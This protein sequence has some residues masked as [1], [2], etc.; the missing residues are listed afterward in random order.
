MNKS[1]DK[2]VLKRFG[3]VEKLLY[4]CIRFSN[5]ENECV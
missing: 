4:L 2:K 1:F 5:G 3:S